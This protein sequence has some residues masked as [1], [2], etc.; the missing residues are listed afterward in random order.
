MPERTVLQPA[1]DRRIIR[2]SCLAPGKV[3]A[4]ALLG[5]LVPAEF[6]GWGEGRVKDLMMPEVGLVPSF[7]EPQKP[8]L[9]RTLA[10]NGCLRQI[11]TDSDNWTVSCHYLDFHS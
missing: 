1:Q 7:R 3:P 9:F 5:R 2:H 10:R 11:E 8:S 6:E 4:S